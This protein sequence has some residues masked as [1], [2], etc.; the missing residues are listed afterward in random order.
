[1]TLTGSP[2]EVSAPKQTVCMKIHNRKLL[3][4]TDCC[5]RG[6]IR[7]T[8]QSAVVPRFNATNETYSDGKSQEAQN[9]Y[10]PN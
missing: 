6:K 4:K 1:M 8:A 2:Q 5:L 3:V 9:A 10:G 7:R